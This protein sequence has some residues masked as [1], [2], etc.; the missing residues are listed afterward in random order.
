MTAKFSD[1]PNGQH[2]VRLSASV[3]VSIISLIITVAVLIGTVSLYIAERPTE[4]RVEKI[5]RDIVNAKVD[6]IS[7][8]IDG[9]TKDIQYL[10]KEREQEQQQIASQSF[11]EDR[12]V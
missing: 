5:A 6:V 8:K 10:R 1:N 7:E 4:E 9:L 3:W 2:Q 12:Y 11:R